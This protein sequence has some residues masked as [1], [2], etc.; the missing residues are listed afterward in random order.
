[1]TKTLLTGMAL[2]LC[3]AL[4]GPARAQ[5]GIDMAALNNAIETQRQITEA[6]RQQVVTQAIQLDAS[7][8]EAF[9]PLYREYRADV[10]KLDDRFVALI[11]D[12]AE[13]YD[14]LNDED[15]L[16]LLKTSLKL[17]ADRIKLSQRYVRR[18]DRI[19]PSTKVARFMQVESRLDAVLDLK[20]KSGIPLAQ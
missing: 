18:F 11:K 13:R 2:T 1:M 5:D 19:M 9:W 15:A 7:Q 6:Q 12:F 8:S 20:V 17:E 10:A 16:R 4:G 3:L 14:T